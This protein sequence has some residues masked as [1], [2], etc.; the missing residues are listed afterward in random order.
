M[1]KIVVVTGASGGI[2]IQTC[3]LLQNEGYFVIGTDRF[4]NVKDSSDKFFQGDVTDESLWMLISTYIKN[5]YGR[6]DG[7]VNIAGI[8]Y[9]SQIQDTSL[10][11][12]REM[13]NVNVVGMVAGIKHLTPL[14]RLGQSSS[15][16]NMSSIAAQIGSDGYSAYSATKGAIDSLTKGLALELAPKIRVNAVAPGWIETQFTVEGLEKSDDPM[17]Y[18][19]EVEKMH[20]LGRVGL[21]VEIANVIAWLLGEKASFLT[22]TTVTADGGYLVKN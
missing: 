8:N 22:G 14:L 13:F 20:A 16:V 4:C 7:L 15:I 2:G 21:P 5:E 18:R 11:S 19:K 9:L 10:D 17:A 12:W 6:C 3:Q 1:K